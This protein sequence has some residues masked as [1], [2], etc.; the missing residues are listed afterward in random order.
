MARLGGEQPRSHALKWR[1]SPL[2]SRRTSSGG[3]RRSSSPMRPLAGSWRT[4][5][6]PAALWATDTARVAARCSQPDEPIHTVLRSSPSSSSL[7]LLSSPPCGASLPARCRARCE[8]R[9][10]RQTGQFHQ[11]GPRSPQQP[12]PRSSVPR[13]SMHVQPAGCDLDRSGDGWLGWP[14][15]PEMERTRLR[16]HRIVLGRERALQP[17]APSRPK[18]SQHGA[19]WTRCRRVAGRRFPARTRRGRAVIVCCDAALGA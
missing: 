12:R 8:A 6:A 3:Q 19:R 17:N 18:S 10:P 9:S 4:Q 1:R 7:L 14:Y 16:Q 11:R 5:A 15:A 2:G 13:C